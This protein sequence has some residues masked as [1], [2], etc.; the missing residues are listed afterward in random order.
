[1]KK[2]FVKVEGGSRGEVE[3]VEVVNMSYE[4]VV[5]WGLKKVG[6]VVEELEEEGDEVDE[7]MSVYGVEGVMVIV[8]LSEENSVGFYEVEGNDKLKELIENY[9]KMDMSEVW[10]ILDEV[11]EKVEGLKKEFYFGEEF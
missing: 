1:M 5:E 11:E 9:D 10:D 8:G 4:E 2:M 6:E 7:F 3:G